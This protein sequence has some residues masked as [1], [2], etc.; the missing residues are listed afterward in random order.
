M[1]AARFNEHSG[2]AAVITHGERSRISFP[3]AFQ[4]DAFSIPTA[5]STRGPCPSHSPFTSIVNYN[6]ENTAF[7]D[8]K[9][10]GSRFK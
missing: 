4:N 3:G 10:T 5:P 1:F 2:N 9:R 6:R 8:I 7:R